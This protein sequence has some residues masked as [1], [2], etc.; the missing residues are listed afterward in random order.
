MPPNVVPLKLI[1]NPTF[2]K[3][4]QA[5]TVPPEVY[6]AVVVLAKLTLVVLQAVTTNEPL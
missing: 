2:N 1:G 3:F 5:E 4:V 6:V